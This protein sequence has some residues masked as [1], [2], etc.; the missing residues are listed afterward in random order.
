[1]AVIESWV[2]QDLKKPVQVRYIKGNIFQDDNNGNLFGVIV[3]DDGSPATLSGAVVGYCVRSNGTAVPVAGTLSSNKAS[4]V[5]PDSAYAVPGPMNIIIKLTGSSVATTLAFIV[6]TVVGIG[7]INATPSDQTIEEWTQQINA[8]IT[9][10][11]NGAVR[12]DASQSLT[13]SQKLQA[14][15]NIGANTSA[16]LVSNDDYKIV[17]P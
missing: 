5:L 14:R 1:M 10:L 15:T 17:I 16:V 4:I 7:S 6:A 12:Y 2:S 13:T 9:A 3:T 8:T 11:E